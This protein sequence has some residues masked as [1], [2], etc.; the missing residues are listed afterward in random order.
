V[1]DVDVGKPRLPWTA[2]GDGVGRATAFGGGRRAPGRGRGRWPWAW[3]GTTWD[4]QPW[5]GAAAVGS[6]R[7]PWARC[8]GWAS[9]V[10]T[11]GRRA[12]GAAAGR[13]LGERRDGGGATGER[14][15]GGAATSAGGVRA[16]VGRTAARARA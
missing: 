16:V 9:G 11:A 7:R 15:G 14:G 1:D 8:G 2:A 12:S 13:R 10:T 4:R 5:A 6:L 3:G